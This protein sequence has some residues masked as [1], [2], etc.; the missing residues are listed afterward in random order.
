MLCL[1]NEYILG[2]LYLKKKNTGQGAGRPHRRMPNHTERTSEKT[3]LGERPD[4]RQISFWFFKKC[5][6][7]LRNDIL[8]NT[9]MVPKDIHMLMRK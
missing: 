3:A 4:L 7:F 8:G 9:M 6:V 2:Q 5:C 1:S